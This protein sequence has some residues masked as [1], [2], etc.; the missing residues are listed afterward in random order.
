M[1]YEGVSLQSDLL[2]HRAAS[3]QAVRF[4]DAQLITDGEDIPPR[5]QLRPPAGSQGGSLSKIEIDDTT[6]WS[7][8]KRPFPMTFD[9]YAVESMIS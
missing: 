6:Y 1:Q 2:C 8:A 5:V 4:R 3:D 7:A 9:L